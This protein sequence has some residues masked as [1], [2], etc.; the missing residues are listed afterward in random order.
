MIFE[1]AQFIRRVQKPNEPVDDFI[2]CLHSLVDR[3][4]YGTLKEEMIRDRLV[5]GLNDQSLS[6]R[7]QMDAELTLKKAV[8]LARS[9]ERVKKQQQVLRN[10]S[11]GVVE[12]V[13]QESSRRYF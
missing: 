4:D 9:S 8:D 7:L 11:K 10:E 3:C 5:V 1:R 6:E 12:A 2:T 13:R